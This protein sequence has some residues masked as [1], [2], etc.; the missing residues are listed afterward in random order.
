[1]SF[2][3]D[4]HPFVEIDNFKGRFEKG[5]TGIKLSLDKNI[6]YMRSI[7]AKNL[8][9][10]EHFHDWIE[11]IYIVKGKMNYTLGEESFE[12]SSGDLL[13]NNYNVHHS[14]NVS[15]PTD[16][17]FFQ[18]KHGF[19]EQ[20]V[21]MFN[22]A[23][24]H[25]RLTDNSV[26][27]EKSKNIR[28]LFLSTAELFLGETELDSLGFK[29]HLLLFLY[30]LIK[31]FSVL[32]EPLPQN[33]MGCGAEYVSLI[34]DYMHKHYR[35]N[36]TLGI[37]SENFHLAS[38]YISR[39]FKEHLGICFKDYLNQIRLNN[40]IYLLANTE[41]SM[42]EISTECGFPNNKSFID[43]FKQAYGET[44]SQYRKQHSIKLK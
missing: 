39:L 2:Y 9:V 3:N 11:F 34:L 44:P 32:L 25:C 15:E 5:Y 33:D 40:A 22:S 4:G 35:E 23:S 28:E 12:L 36:I 17:I 30:Y 38:A 7:A 6:S 18:L 26:T 19:I 31:D 14:Y 10:E 41:N 8:V 43:S 42:L 37:L 13:M 16:V 20:L 29:S 24:I 21:P 1:M 27:P